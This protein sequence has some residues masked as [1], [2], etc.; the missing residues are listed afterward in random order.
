MSTLA[1]MM[2]AYGSR[3]LVDAGTI[4]VFKLEELLANGIVPG[5][6]LSCSQNPTHL[7]NRTST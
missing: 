7:E 1:R 2:A 3:R 5:I 6:Y 4:E